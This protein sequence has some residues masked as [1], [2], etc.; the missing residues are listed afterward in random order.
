[1][2]RVTP[3]G[4]GPSQVGFLFGTG[5]VYGFLA[6][7][8][9]AGDPSPWSAARTLARGAASSFVGG[10]TIRRMAKPF[11]GSV[12]LHD[13]T[14]WP[15]RDYLAIA[16]GTVAHIGLQFM[17]FYRYDQTP[18]MFQALGIYASAAQ[19]VGELPRLLRAKPMRPNRAYDALTPQMRVQS[20]HGPLRYTVDGE[21]HE[22]GPGGFVTVSIG[23]RLRLL[24]AGAS[25]RRRSFTC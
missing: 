24:T 19:F 23:P 22:A 5:V 14:A 9:G 15:E 7:Y 8:Y 2:L 18:G 3:D 21:L 17:P 6:E 4:G 20:G 25:G 1:V 13:G 12:T 11:R 10:E 16:A